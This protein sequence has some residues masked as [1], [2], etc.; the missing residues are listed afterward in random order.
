MSETKCIICLKK[1]MKEYYG[2]NTT[3]SI[4]HQYTLTFKNGDKQ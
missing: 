2:F 3:N 1:L 4:N